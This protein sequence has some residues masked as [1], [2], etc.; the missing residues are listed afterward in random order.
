MR[1]KKF[2]FAHL[3]D[4]ELVRLLR[5]GHKEARDA[6]SVRYFNLR[7]KLVGLVSNDAIRFLDEWDINEAFF[8]AYLKTEMNY[9][10]DK[11]VK[12]MSLMCV[13]L[14]HEIINLL[15]HVHSQNDGF[16]TYSLDNS[17]A[18]ESEEETTVT[19][20]ES[21]YGVAQNESSEYMNLLSVIKTLSENAKGIGAKAEEFVEYIVKGYSVRESSVLCHLSFSQGRTLLAKIKKAMIEYVK[22]IDKPD[23][24]LSLIEDEEEEKEET[25]KKFSK[26]KKGRKDKSGK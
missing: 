9:R 11:N 5:K 3:T 26:R 23:L 24:L 10:F 14:R 8:A 22:S 2:G 18:P 20:A 19:F 6:L 7:K 15:K 21:A 25:K 17:I 12:F 13:N 1:K 16:Y 4:E